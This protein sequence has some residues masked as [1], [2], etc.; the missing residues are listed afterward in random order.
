MDMDNV[1]SRLRKFVSEHPEMSKNGLLKGIDGSGK[2]II[3]VNGEERHITIDDLERAYSKPNTEEKIEVMEDINT[4]IAPENI[5]IMDNS[6]SVKQ[7]TT[8]KDMQDAVNVKDEISINKALETFAIDQNTGTINMNKAIKIVTD[9][10][11]ENVINCIR[12]NKKLPS[13][14]SGYDITGNIVEE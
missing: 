14:L 6:T 9:N 1:V 5:E 12:D 11:I 10:S 8:L 2:V 7:I 13:D 4:N 3:V